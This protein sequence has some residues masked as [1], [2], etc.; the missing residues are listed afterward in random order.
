[1]VDVL[2]NGYKI[3]FRQLPGQYEEPNNASVLRNMDTVVKIVLELRDQKVIEFVSSKPICVSPLGLVSKTVEGKQRHRLVF[4]ASRWINLHVDPPSVKLTHL[5]KA[6]QLT[7]PNDYQVIFDLKSAYYNVKIDPSHVQ[8]LGA[9]IDIEG[10]KQYFVFKHLPFGLNSSVSAMTKLWKPITGH[11]HKQGI[12]FS[13]YIDDGRILAENAGKAEE[14][15]KRVYE[16]IEK[17]GWSMAWEKSDGPLEASQVKTYLG[18]IIDS[19]KMTV[20]YPDQKLWDFCSRLSTS[21]EKSTV[22]V[23]TLASM[24]GKLISLRPSHGNAVN[25]CSRS[26]Y[27][28]LESHVDTQGWVGSIKWSPSA[29]KELSLFVENAKNFN[30]SPIINAL[31]DLRV[32]TIFQDPITSQETIKGVRADTVVV[33]DASQIKAAVKYLTGSQSH[34]TSTFSFT[35]NEKMTSSGYRELL[36]VYKF[37]QQEQFSGRLEAANIVW[38][39]DSTNLVSFLSKGSSK[40]N[41]QTV[42]FEILSMLSTLKSVLSPVHL[43]REDERIQQADYLSKLKDSDNWS[44]DDHSFQTFHRDFQFELD[45]FADVKNRKVPRFMSRCYHVETQAVDA[46]S[47]SW[48]G[49]AWVCPPTSLIS[50]TV[51]RIQHSNCQGLLIVPNWP[52]S[53]FFNELFEHDKVVAPF[54]FISEFKPYIF[55]NEGASNTP[56]FGVP[57]FTF[58]ALYF[59]TL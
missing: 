14:D 50:K 28:L 13:I 40:G 11:I 52:A 42:V 5:E 41:I 37:L 57:K 26:G 48:I 9:A 12:R 30:S 51:K 21:L 32:D 25:I 6:L 43:F 19:N 54:Q 34:W 39:T 15:R 35:E 53:E 18:F 55:Q 31:T 38:A 45:V 17:T 44:I 59:N 23:K 47:F 33:S 24:L 10:Q 2:E 4:D 22:Q 8:Y 56:L 27:V 20:A 7:R 16:I 3:P 36:A 49:M 46:F 58:F 1:M 29:I